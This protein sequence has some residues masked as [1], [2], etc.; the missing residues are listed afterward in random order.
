[1]TSNKPRVLLVAEHAS[2]KFGGEAALP[3]HYFRVLRKRQIE[4][5]MIVHERTRDELKL[6]L[7]EDFDRVYF[8]SD[9]FLHRF[10]WKIGCLLPQR[11][12][13]VTA[14]FVSRLTT[15][16][17]QRLLVRKTVQLHRINVIHQ[18]IPVSPKEPSLIFDVGAPVI[19]GPMNGGMDYPPSFRHMQSRFVHLSFEVGRLVA[20]WLNYLLPGKRRA[21]ALLVANARTRA[22]LPKGACDCVIE[23]YENGIDLS[24]WEQKLKRHD[25]A[26]TRSSLD[27]TDRHTKFVFVGRLVHWKAVDLLLQAFV[28]VAQT[29]PVELEII[30]DGPECARLKEQ[31]SALGLLHSETPQPGD[32]VTFVGWLSQTEC[33]QRLQQSDVMVLPSLL[34]C[35]G[36]VVL[37]SMAMGIPVIA[38]N[39]GGPSDYLNDSCG[40]LVEPRSQDLFV[41]DLAAAMIRMATSPALRQAMG[42]MGYYRAVSQFDWDVK[43]DVILEIY[44]RVLDASLASRPLIMP[45]GAV[46]RV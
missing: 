4:V 36:A 24:L 37:E 34:E 21:A 32:Q 8:V 14:G 16:L 7:E 22:A 27:I 5:W 20:N 3:L 29:L 33:A 42:Q 23:L 43:A 19:I 15:Q 2:A 10:L 11:L 25:V 41:D 40:I 30:G 45:D 35:G 17:T 39:W 1:M 38:T 28:R 26:P 12:A 18:P 31:A 46:S 13:Y 9:T 44:R 6:L